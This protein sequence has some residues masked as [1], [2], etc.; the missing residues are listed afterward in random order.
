MGRCDI[1]SLYRVLLPLIGQKHGSMGLFSSEEKKKLVEGIAL[2]LPQ[3]KV[4]KGS[5]EGVIMIYSDFNLSWLL[6]HSFIVC[7]WSDCGWGF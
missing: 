6:V 5:D 2:W 7:K 1:Y 4:N 3:R